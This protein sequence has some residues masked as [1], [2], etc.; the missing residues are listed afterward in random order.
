MTLSSTDPYPIIQIQPDWVLEPEAMGSKNKF[1]F[2]G[3]NGPEWLFKFPQANTGQHWSE[4]IAAEVADQLD[5]LHARVE[6][7]QFQGCGVRQLSRSRGR[8]VSCSTVTS[9]WLAR[10]LTMIQ[11]S[12]FG[13]RTTL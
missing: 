1:W 13:S 12:G 3:D 11:A 8:G 4:K 6:L 9:S 5:V 7:A 2:R 10:P